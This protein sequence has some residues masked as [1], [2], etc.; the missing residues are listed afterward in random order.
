MPETG[1][2]DA[3]T[4]A[5]LRGRIDAV[6]ESIHRLLIERA[7]VIDALIAA[8]GT[9]RSG[10]AFRP[11]REAEM[12]RKLA[13]R[14]SGHLP[15]A[16]VEHL[17]REI[18]TTFTYLQAP[19]RVVVDYGSDPL[20]MRDV[21][22]FVFGFTVSLDAADG[23][24]DVVKRIAASRSDLGVVPLGDGSA[25][26]PWWRSLSL[27]RGPRVMALLPF[28]ELGGRPAATPAVVVSP[29]LTEPTAPDILVF[30]A[31]ASAAVNFPPR[32]AIL[33]RAGEEAMVAMAGSDAEAE[34]AAAGA[35]DI[36]AIGGIAR[37][38]S[39]DGLTGPLRLPAGKE[40]RA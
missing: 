38:I 20:A 40:A 26:T 33:A 16:A 25:G 37:G 29:P 24:A 3:T 35:A 1:E 34:L 10:A 15:L 8:K 6:D 17:W 2:S 7:S 11:Q 19:F 18:I 9:Q 27:T 28:I 5:A 32:A 13:A 23:P 21:A 39:A 14:H 4:L 36:A 22:R 31:N 30:A 12:M